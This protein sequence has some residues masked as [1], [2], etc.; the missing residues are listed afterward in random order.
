MSLVL[1]ENNNPTMFIT[2]RLLT[3]IEI[4]SRQYETVKLVDEDGYY[5]DEIVKVY[6]EE[7]IISYEGK[8][9]QERTIKLWDLRGDLYEL[10]YVI[11]PARPYTIPDEKDGHRL[12]IGRYVMHEGKAAYVKSVGA[13]GN[14]DLVEVLSKS[15]ETVPYQKVEMIEKFGVNVFDLNKEPQLVQR[16]AYDWILELDVTDKRLLNMIHSKIQFRQAAQ[17]YQRVDF[18]LNQD[19]IDT[20]EGNLHLSLV[21]V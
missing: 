6:L 1:R 12:L 14:V 11:S 18:P 17:A 2:E 10:T 15:I 9:N 7:E 19:S 8:W 13:N 5:Y 3:Q 4:K 20:I 21:E 16:C